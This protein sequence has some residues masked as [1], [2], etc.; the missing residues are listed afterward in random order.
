MKSGQPA[1]RN[2]AAVLLRAVQ[3]KT[4]VRLTM[5]A[6]PKPARVSQRQ[7]D[8]EKAMRMIEAEMLA[9]LKRCEELERDL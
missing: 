6:V 5:R 3:R 2:D 8:R 7:L 9:S 4:G 1:S